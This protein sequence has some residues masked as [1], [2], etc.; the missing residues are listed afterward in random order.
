MSAGEQG[1]R[2]PTSELRLLNDALSSPNVRITKRLPSSKDWYND[3]PLPPHQGE[4]NFQF[5][6]LMSSPSSSTRE[7]A[8]KKS[9]TDYNLL[10]N[11][12]GTGISHSKSMVSGEDSFGLGLFGSPDVGFKSDSLFSPKMLKAADDAAM[13]PPN[14]LMSNSG[15]MN[16]GI[17]FNG[18]DFSVS[19]NSRSPATRRKSGNSRGSSGSG[20]RSRKKSKKHDDHESPLSTDNMI[21][22]LK[23]SG[24]RT[25]KKKL[26]DASDTSITGQSHRQKK[27]HL[28]PQNG[29]DNDI[30]GLSLSTPPENS[31][32]QAR[33]KSPPSGSGANGETGVKCNCK[34][35]RCLKL[36]CDCF[37]INKY[38]NNCNCIECSNCVE[39]DEERSVVVQNILERNPDAFA[40]RIKEDPD[41]LEKEKVHLSGCHCKKSACLKKYCE[42]YSAGVHCSSKCRCLDCK[43]GIEISEEEIQKQHPMSPDAYSV[44]TYQSA[45]LDVESLNM[46]MLGD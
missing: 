8:R 11:G 33:T 2:S 38:C 29:G 42:C 44:A 43:N 46:M 25:L 4:E 21:L 1:M 19:G 17:A 28:T 40:P 7:S 18:V 36:Y 3:G 22:T 9:R 27:S 34:K 41:S 45:N 23:T 20:G 15:R 12:G 26:S 24:G 6:H 16:V 14:S 39:K 37:R 35:S 13:S 10:N 31:F 5:M 30:E 32:S